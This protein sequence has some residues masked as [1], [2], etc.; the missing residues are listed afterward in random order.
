MPERTGSMT[1]IP[2]LTEVVGEPAEQAE[3]STGT[4]SLVAEL[5][6]HLAASTFAL[7]EQLLRSALADVEAAVSDRVTTKL[8][9]QL[10]ELIDA[11]LRRHFATSERD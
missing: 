2:M 5:Q 3:L 9:E 11:V 7:T 1:H 4:E 6:I 8:R 10:P